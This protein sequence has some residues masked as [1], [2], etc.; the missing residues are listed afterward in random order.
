MITHSPEY[1]MFA[2]C[3]DLRRIAITSV[4][5]KSKCELDASRVDFGVPSVFTYWRGLA[6][7]LIKLVEA[8]AGTVL[9]HYEEATNNSS[10][11]D[12]VLMHEPPLAAQ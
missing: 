6:Y 12:I 8:I 11:A 10:P 7:S 9:R 2:S 5:N 4:W 3:S 1:E